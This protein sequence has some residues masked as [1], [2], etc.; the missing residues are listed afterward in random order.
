MSELQLAEDAPASTQ[1]GDIPITVRRQ[2]CLSTAAVSFAAAPL[3]P[4]AVLAAQ[5]TEAANY[6]IRIEKASVEIRRGNGTT[7]KM[8]LE[9]LQDVRLRECIRR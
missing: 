5:A 2:Q 7:I 6:A 4:S 1:R 9:K 3:R 8:S